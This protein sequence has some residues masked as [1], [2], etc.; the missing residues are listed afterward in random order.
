MPHPNSETNFRCVINAPHSRL[1]QSLELEAL[2][3]TV[4]QE[5]RPNNGFKESQQAA[6]EVM[7]RADVVN[8]GSYES[9]P[10]NGVSAG[11]EPKVLA[12]P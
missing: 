9:K 10:V 3:R 7:R 5:R 4:N 1:Q 11:L 12:L 2:Q 6:P 8:E